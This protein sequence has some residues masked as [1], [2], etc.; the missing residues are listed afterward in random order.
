MLFIYL[1]EHHL[2]TI[3]TFILNNTHFINIKQCVE[4][5][6]RAVH[7][8]WHIILYSAMTSVILVAICNH[9]GCKYAL[10][11]HESGIKSG[12]LFMNTGTIQSNRNS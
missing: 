7:C 10:E 11:V 5:E 2:V 12:P 3:I 8:R 1:N 9:T 6:V 4:V